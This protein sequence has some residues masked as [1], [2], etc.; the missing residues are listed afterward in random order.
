RSGVGRIRGRDLYHSLLAASWPRFL[1]AIVLTWVALNVAFAVAYDLCGE[2]AIAGAER[3]DAEGRFLE[4]F[5]FSVQTFSTIG[6]GRLAPASVA[7][8]AVATV[9]ALTSLLA[10]A[11]V[12][13]LLF[14]RF[15]RPTARVVF[16]NVAI[17]GTHD[18]GP[19]LVFR[20]ANARLNQIVEAQ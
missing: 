2:G 17:L 16:S 18:G 1:G 10:P 6:Y 11:I 3:R 14:A 5:F 19:A 8:S 20:M 13:G 9:E 15:A 7:A 12:W 4:C